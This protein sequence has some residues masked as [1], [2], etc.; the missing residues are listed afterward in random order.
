MLTAGDLLLKKAILSITCRG[1]L[2]W[3]RDLARLLEDNA[4]HRLSQMEAEGLLH[5]S[6]GGLQVT[7]AGKA[8]IRNICMVFDKKLSAA[9]LANPIFSKAV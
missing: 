8:F 5:L 2:S 4:W 6:P 3:S 9:T 7:E 1:R